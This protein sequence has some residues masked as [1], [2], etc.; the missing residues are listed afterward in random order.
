MHLLYHDLVIEAERERSSKR[1]DARYAAL[2]ALREHDHSSV[3]RRLAVALASVSRASAAAVRRL[4]ECLADD[5]VAHV[6]ANR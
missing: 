5:L 6:V 2:A 4:D 1:G 3:R